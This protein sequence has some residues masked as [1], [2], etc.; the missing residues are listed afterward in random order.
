MNKNNKLTLLQLRKK[1]NIFFQAYWK[2]VHVLEKTPRGL[3]HLTNTYK[4]RRSK[5]LFLT[6]QIFDNVLKEMT[7][8]GTPGNDPV[9]YFSIK[10]LTNTQCYLLTELNRI[11]EGEMLLPDWLSTFKASL[12]PKNDLTDEAKIFR[13]IACPNIAH[14]TYTGI[15]N[16]V[17]KVQYSIN[18]I[19]TLEQ[20]ED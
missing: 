3:R 12:L 20:T 16:K 17:L 7:S 9:T 11:Y 4:N 10:K 8:N 19:I 13:L 5:N 6:Q 1:L 15:K 18:D 2:K 14:K